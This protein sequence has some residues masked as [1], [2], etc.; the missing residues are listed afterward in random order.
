MEALVTFTIYATALAL[1]STSDNDTSDM[2]PG[3]AADKIILDATHTHTAFL[4]KQ[5]V[6]GPGILV[7]KSGVFVPTNSS[8][9]CTNRISVAKKREKDPRHS[10]TQV[11]I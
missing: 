7:V 3:V 8:V 11:L 5:G 10:M 6:P 2:T 4:G 1:E 9:R